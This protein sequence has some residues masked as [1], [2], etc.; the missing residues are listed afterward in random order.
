MLVY[1]RDGPAHTV[2]RAVALRQKSKI[3]LAVSPSHSMLTLGQPVPVLTQAPGRTFT[4]VQVFKSL[5]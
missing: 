2:V 4:G 1:L 3:K 5:V